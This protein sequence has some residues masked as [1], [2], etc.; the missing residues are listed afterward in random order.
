M[1]MDDWFEQS[2]KQFSFRLWDLINVGDRRFRCSG[3]K[4]LFVRRALE[5]TGC[6]DPEFY[7]EYANLAGGKCCDCEVGLNV[8]V[9]F[10]SIFGDDGTALDFHH[11]WKPFKKVFSLKDDITTI[12]HC[13]HAE[14]HKAGIRH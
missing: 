2:A 9:D 13:C 7:L 3:W 12:C 8:C 1:N 6:P 5:D 11:K 4:K 10:R 14:A